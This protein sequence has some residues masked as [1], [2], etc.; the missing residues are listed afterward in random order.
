[1]PERI[2]QTWGEALAVGLTQRPTE[3]GPL[4]I[5]A[6]VIVA[7]DD[8]QDRLEW[9][10]AAHRKALAFH[11]G[12][13]GP[14]GRNFYNKLVKRYG[15]VDAAAE[16]EQLYVRGER[17]RAVRIVPDELVFGTALIGSSREVAARLAAY[18]AAGV[19]MLNLQAGPQQLVEQV[20][21]LADVLRP[22]AA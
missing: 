3:L 1:M 15:F 19:T 7:I 5:A 13:M 21:R 12:A 11:I 4:Q 16:I 20:G 6:D 2:E 8:R 14:P 9:A 10:L 18:S 22:S 17:A